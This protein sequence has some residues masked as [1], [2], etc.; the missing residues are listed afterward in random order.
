MGSQEYCDA[1][2]QRSVGER[3]TSSLEITTLLYANAH[4]IAVQLGPLNGALTVLRE[5]PSNTS[6]GGCSCAEFSASYQ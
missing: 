4:Q 3:V 2:R 1:G 6:K 5:A